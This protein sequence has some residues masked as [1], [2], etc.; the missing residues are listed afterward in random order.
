MEA[1]QYGKKQD[2]RAYIRMQKRYVSNEEKI[3]ASQAIFKHL[4]EM[5]CFRRAETV[6]LYW[7]LPDEV[8]T[9]DFILSWHTRKK[10]LLPVMD[11]NSLKA[12][13]FTGVGQLKND[14][15]FSVPEPQ[16]ESVDEISDIDLIIVPG[17]AF[18]KKNNR[19]GRGKGYYDSFLKD[20][21][22]YRIGVCFA[23]QLVADV[24]VAEHD[25]KMDLVLTEQSCS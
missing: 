2:L 24:P 8:F 16:G 11:G 18:D 20:I 6:M 5:E 19:L 9:H 10:I 4:E 7:S 3:R 14:N 13:P 17:V 23:F 22:T 1:D 12:L 15:A 25:V 21:D